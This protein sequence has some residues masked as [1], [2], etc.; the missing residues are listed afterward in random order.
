MSKG[1]EEAGSTAYPSV[2]SQTAVTDT[3]P[4]PSDSEPSVWLPF[5]FL[6]NP[7][8]SPLLIDSTFITG[9]SES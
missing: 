7:T 1:R 9:E 5:T 6:S 4:Q 2:L 3:K 8:S